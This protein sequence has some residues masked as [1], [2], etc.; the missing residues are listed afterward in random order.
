MTH[1]D[2]VFSP[3]LDLEYITK[4]PADLYTEK[5]FHMTVLLAKCWIAIYWRV[6]K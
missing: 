1:L 5:G 4:A 2:K 6:K 3:K